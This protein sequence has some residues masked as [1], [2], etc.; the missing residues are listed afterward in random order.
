MELNYSLIGLRI[1]KVRKNKKLT[2]DKLSELS[3]ISP[4]HLSQIESGKTK[5]SLPTLINICNA[6]EITTD[7]ILCD[8]L[9]QSEVYLLEDIGRVF[10]DCNKTELS[11]MLSQAENLKKALRLQNIT[12]L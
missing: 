10:S 11:I 3:D 6:L 8:S 4:Q 1:K 5:L 12:V 2:Q 9:P 7:K